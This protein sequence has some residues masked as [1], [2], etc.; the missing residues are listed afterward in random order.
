MVQYS[1]VLY[2][3]SARVVV[4]PG[5]TRKVLY[6]VYCIDGSSVKLYFFFSNDL[7][8]LFEDAIRYIRLYW[9]S[10]AHRQEACMLYMYDDD[11]TLDSFFLIHH[12]KVL[13]TFT[14]S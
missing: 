11:R 10:V 9:S 2:C 6:C 4:Q 5:T 1:A 13:E 7:S 3:T 12:I 14:G 8:S